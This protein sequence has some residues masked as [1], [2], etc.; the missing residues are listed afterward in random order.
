MNYCQHRCEVSKILYNLYE[1][2][3]FD[4][5]V[6][7]RYSFLDKDARG[8]GLNL[9]TV[10]ALAKFTNEVIL[11][12]G[13]IP[14]KVYTKHPVYAA[15]PIGQQ[16]YHPGFKLVNR[17]LSYDLYVVPIEMRLPINIKLSKL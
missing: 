5:A 17:I 15:I 16:T 8:Y 10:E 4:R 6:Y 14:V 1:E 12:K 3:N 9:Q 13:Q 7:L 2:Y 11:V